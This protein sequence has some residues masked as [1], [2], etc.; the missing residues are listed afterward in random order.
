MVQKIFGLKSLTK[1]IEL[2]GEL[3]GEKSLYQM[4]FGIAWPAAL[5]GLLI[6]MISSVDLIMVGALG[7]D[8]VAAVGI[9]SQPRMIILCFSRS[10]AVAI[11]A[12][13]ARRKGE[14]KTGEL[15]HCLKQGF[16]LTSLLCVV[17][18]LLSVIFLEE[19]LWAAG[20]HREYM[21]LAVDYGRYNML[22]IFFT[23]L[24]VGINA[25]QTGVG[26]TRIILLA[27]VSG[28]AVNTVLNL[29]LI[30]GFLFFPKM[31]VSGAGLATLIGS[32][33]S[34][35]ISLWSVMKKDGEL[36]L[37]GWQGWKP[38]SRIMKSYLKVGSSAFAEQIFERIGMFLYSYMVAG[39]GTVA[40]ATHYICMNLCDV[41]YSFSQGM[42]KASSAMT[43][44]KLGEGRKD[45]AFV[46]AK[47]GRRGGLILD[48][49]AF[50]IYLFGRHLL[51][52]LYSRDAQV[53]GL[54]GNILI[55]VAACV[56]L[57]TQSMIYAG[58]LRG[59][60]DTRYV[61]AYSFW[62]IAILRPV[63]TYVLC[64]PLGLGIYGAWISLVMDQF[65]RTFFST[66]RFYSKKWMEIQL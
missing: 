18:L 8:A 23:G 55:F 53:I 30:Y 20:A 2:Q 33:V 38:D 11:T 6:M 54:G 56:F 46:S 50:C 65:L 60:G 62:D 22:A 26:N 17:I 59:A 28:N 27:N 1:G 61:A 4:F 39:L 37:G 29:F 47:A 24:S 45:L 19:I 16:L 49:A 58:V 7:T 12:L 66:K 14:G 44:Q 40:F 31:G 21:E 32:A 15:N 10:L 52:F 51:M 48:A 57:Q 3:P 13:T 34:F 64:F 63:I 42:S 9:T 41:Y 36:Y 35:G 43:G 25:A 5:E